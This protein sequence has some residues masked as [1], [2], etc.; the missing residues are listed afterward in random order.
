MSAIDTN[1]IYP[2]RGGAVRKQLRVRRSTLFLLIIMILGLEVCYLALYPWLAGRIASDPLLQSWEALIP[3]SSKIY[4][5]LD[6]FAY[7]ST[8]SWPEPLYGHLYPLLGVLGIILFFI[9]LAV[10]AGNR[11]GRLILI[12]STL[13]LRPIFWTIL[14]SGILMAMTMFFA[15]VHLSELTRSMLQSG[16]YGRIVATYHLN[17]YLSHSAILTH[18]PL[19]ALVNR[20]PASDDVTPGA[21]GPVWMDISILISLIAH[22]DGGVMVLAW[23]VLALLAH[24]LNVV[25]IWSLLS[26]QKPLYR[27]SGTILYAWNPLVLVLGIAY[28]HPEI[29]LV[30]LMLLALLSFQ[31]DATLL[32][33]V[34]ALLASLISLYSILLLPLLFVYA[35]RR[36]RLL[37]CGWFLLW[38][39]GMLLVTA[40]VL[41]LAYIPYWQGWGVTGILLGIRDIFW[42]EGAV[43]SLNAAIINMP[44]QLPANILW[45]FQPHNWS[46]AALIIILLYLLITVWVID[47]FEALLQC[48]GW[49]LLLWTILQPTYWPWYMILPFIVATSTSNRRETLAAI[50]LLSGALISYYFW[51]WSN[52]WEGQGL[53]IIGIP[54][55][56]WGWAL[57]F[58]A[59][60]QM[61]R[62]NS[63][64]RQFVQ[65][66]SRPQKLQRP[67]WFSRPWTSR[68]NR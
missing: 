11:A 58:H 32:G 51:Q 19:Q 59:T 64:R 63:S 27:I 48:S 26:A 13:Y 1:T 36:A 3:M 12:R 16:L 60:W 9:W 15:P 20:L 10:G 57:F 39:L 35:L 30:S 56:L 50:L 18:D 8:F 7:I 5:R 61:L 14:V 37:G 6:W 21:V 66:E 47:T 46:L 25:L 2:V 24:I 65:D 17:P 29:L 38:T 43:N 52:I 34:F 45:T 40:L 67:P 33:W 42:Q 4:K 49:L 23:R 31:R 28:V 41:V 62:G 53:A 55:L 54:C 68:P 44:I 22:A